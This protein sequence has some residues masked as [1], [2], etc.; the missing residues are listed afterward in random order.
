MQ[1]NNTNVVFKEETRREIEKT[2]IHSYLQQACIDYPNNIILEDRYSDIRMTFAEF[3]AEVNTLASALQSLGIKKGDKVSLFSENNARWMVVDQAILRSGAADAVRGSAAPVSELEYIIEQS[4]SVGI[5]LKDAAL[6]ESLKEKIKEFS[7]KF[8]MIMFS[9]GLDKEGA[10]F[11]LYTY[12]DM[13]ELGGQKAFEPVEV[14]REDEATL[15][16]TS[17]TTN[18]PKGVVLTH[19]NLMSQPEKLHESMGIEPG[20]TALCVL[21]VWHVYER[22]LEYYLLSRGVTF[23]YTNIM[24]VRSDMAKYHA[25]Y[26]MAVPRIW[27]SICNI[28]KNSVKGRSKNYAKMFNF[29]IAWSTINKKALRYLQRTDIHVKEYNIFGDIFNK[30]IH[31]LT[32]PLHFLFK[33]VFYEKLI[34]QFG[35]GFEL[36]VSGGGSL[37]PVFADFFE[38]MELD[39]IVG[40]GLTETSPVLTINGM[41]APLV[42][43]KVLPVPYSA[44]RALPGTEIKIISPETNKQLGCYEKGV[45][46]VRG[47][48]VMSKGY[49]KDAEATKAVL[50]DD[51]WFNT[52]DLGWMTNRGDL[53]L[54]G[55][56]K[57]II[58]LSNGENIEP[59]PIEQTC[60]ESPYI[61]QIMLVGQDR[62]V[63]GAL[64]VHAASAYQKFGS[65]ATPT[66]G[67]KEK[68]N[69][70]PEFREFF[71]KEITSKM[72][73]KSHFRSFE[74]VTK[75]EF[76]AE[77][78]SPAN[79]LLTSS[80]KM[81]RNV[82]AERHAKVI[83]KMY[84]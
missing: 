29:A 52:G 66:V 36:S 46:F 16:Y 41:R 79:G 76:L 78:F 48:Q 83:D 55:R 58:V 11:P 74:R 23:L 82:I 37:A 14:N 68:I 17:G 15:I 65:S 25:A 62:T 30:A 35:I 67:E 12:E 59:S 22:G 7:P 51:G 3:D 61:N 19:G 13:I 53:I 50:S 57:E 39:L 10:E 77:E 40:Y 64:I 24:N 73:S 20:K 71:R 38:A 63:I 8:V 43:E 27:E 1:V 81:K 84:A 47:A 2:S 21:P 42:G 54:T 28:V 26:M 45:V 4:D 44:G 72:K 31:L 5:V 60:L 80:A 69:K 18:R 6:Y 32:L 75:F 9:K 34:N 49:Y 56:E 33:K 70:L